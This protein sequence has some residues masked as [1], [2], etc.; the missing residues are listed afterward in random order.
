MFQDRGS[1]AKGVCEIQP[2]FLRQISEP[3]SS[4]RLPGRSSLVMASVGRSEAAGVQAQHCA[5]CL[6]LSNDVPT[7]RPEDTAIAATTSFVAWP[8]VGSLVEGWLIVVPRSHCLALA[9]LS[10]AEQ[11]ELTELV[12]LLTAALEVAYQGSVHT[13]EHGPAAPG[14]S[15]GCSIDHAHLHIVP[16]QFDLASAARAFEPRLTWLPAGNLSSLRT[17]HRN[18]YPYLWIRSP[19]GS[20]WVTFDIDVP[21]QFFRRVIADELDLGEPEWRREP[22]PEVAARTVRTLVSA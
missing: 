17:Q 20:S 18:G 15:L 9:S 1:R 7:G 22:R 19:N 12:S 3:M 5:F 13:F 16:L 4:D 2:A 8:S 21:S 10:D 11:F 14:T 6:Q